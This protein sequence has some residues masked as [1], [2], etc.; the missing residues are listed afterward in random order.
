MYIFLLATE[1]ED[2]GFVL[3]VTL[4]KDVKSLKLSKRQ[5]VL[6]VVKQSLKE[7]EKT[8]ERVLFHF[9]DIGCVF[10]S[11]ASFFLARNKDLSFHIREFQ[12]CVEGVTEAE[13]TKIGISWMDSRIK[14]QEETLKQLRQNKRALKEY[15]ESLPCER[16]QRSLESKRE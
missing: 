15:L 1:N 10:T 11:D 3:S 4:Q 9:T 12:D 5:Q 8:L 16:K 6:E 7:A 14:I 13:N 2:R